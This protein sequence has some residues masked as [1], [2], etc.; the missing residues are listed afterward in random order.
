MKKIITKKAQKEK[1]KRQQLTLGLVLIL[2]LV[3]SAFGVVVG[4][5]G[6][7][8]QKKIVYNGLEFFPLNDYWK[9]DIGEFSFFFRYNPLET[10]NISQ[11]FENKEIPIATFYSNKPL[12]I[13]SFNQLA[14]S[15]IY[16][17][18]NL[19]VERFQNACLTEEN[20]PE[21]YPIK[22]CSEN[23][24][25]ILESEIPEIEIQENC[26]F[27]KGDYNNI[28]ILTDEFLFR[29]LGIKS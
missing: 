10:E 6:S 20:C 9:T 29:T 27:I 5:F 8:E 28:L 1:Q 26:I 13:S 17:N 3:M 15:E 21:N 18:T 4:S 24:I 7:N 11:Y 25:I 12:Y 14:T 19:F 22:N 2:I 16:Q 23:F